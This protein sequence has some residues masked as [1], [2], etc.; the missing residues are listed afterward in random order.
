MS[1]WKSATEMCALTQQKV[2]EYDNSIERRVP[3]YMDKA[4]SRIHASALHRQF[5]C[6]VEFN[7]EIA[8]DKEV[9]GDIVNA[10]KRHLQKL[11]YTVKPAN[12]ISLQIEWRR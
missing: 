9:I 12:R 5:S 6:T 2:Q 7:P 10:I 4:M 1:N 11:G 3:Q 8:E